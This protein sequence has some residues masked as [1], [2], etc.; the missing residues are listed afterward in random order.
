MQPGPEGESPDPERRVSE[1]AKDLN[2]WSGTGRLCQDP[3]LKYTPTGVAVCSLRLA[4]NKAKEEQ[5]E[6]ADFLTVEVWRQAAEFAAN[7]LKTGSQVSTQGRLRIRKWVAQDGSK[8][9][10]AEIVANELNALGKSV[11]SH[12]D[13]DPAPAAAV[14]DA[15][16]NDPFAD[17]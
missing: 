8:R 3:E 9:Q 1:V 17:E 5:G 4:V 15:D 10:S 7:Y 6:K 16:F 13:E 12:A 11:P 2:C 14:S